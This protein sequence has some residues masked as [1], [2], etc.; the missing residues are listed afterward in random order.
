MLLRSISMTLA[1]LLPLTGYA[2]IQAAS[3]VGCTGLNFTVTGSTPIGH[4]ATCTALS[5]DA[6][7]DITTFLI[8]ATPTRCSP[9]P[10]WT[11]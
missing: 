7:G 8:A 10:V 4:Q 2:K 3:T 5:L 6:S 9:S 11:T 1:L